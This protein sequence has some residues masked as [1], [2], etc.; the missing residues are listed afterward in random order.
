M[1]DEEKGLLDAICAKDSKSFEK[2]YC[3]HFKGIFS[4]AYRYVRDQEVAEELANDVFLMLWRDAGKLTISKSLGAYLSRCIVNSSINYLKSNRPV[5]QDIDLVRD[6]PEE[7]S[8][9]DHARE[10]EQKLVFLEKAIHG[11]PA[12][13]RKVLW[14][15]KFEMKKQQHIADELG[16]SIK[17]VKNHLTLAYEKIRTFM[18]GMPLGLWLLFFLFSVLVNWITSFS[19]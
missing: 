10:L 4:L 1:T 11:L 13:C 7:E 2:L 15:S 12:Q 9:I 8:G 19:L 6:I 18:V 16:I 17:T 3:L 14:M 5:Y